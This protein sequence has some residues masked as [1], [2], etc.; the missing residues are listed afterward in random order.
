M[1]IAIR[2]E[3]II[4]RN[5]LINFYL[6]HKSYSDAISFLRKTLIYDKMYSDYFANK[7]LEISV[8]SVDDKN[9]RFNALYDAFKEDLN[10]IGKLHK[11]KF[12]HDSNSG[13]EILNH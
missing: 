2:P 1:A 13:N 5:Q 9:E 6:K 11:L 4:L 12:I 8:K 10:I 3:E 7:Y